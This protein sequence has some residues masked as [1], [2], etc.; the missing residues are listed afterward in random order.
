MT[1]INPFQYKTPESL[2]A[3]EIASVFVDVYSDFSKLKDITHTFI[4]GSRGTGKSMMLRYLEPRVLLQAGEIKELSELSFF[5]VHIPVKSPSL[6]LTEL[7]RLTGSAYSSF[8]EY[9]LV[10]Y[11]CQKILRLLSFLYDKLQYQD[12]IESLYRFFKEQLVLEGWQ[13]QTIENEKPSFKQ[14]ELICDREFTK[15]FQYLKRLSFCSQPVDYNGPLLGY[16]DFLLALVKNIK[17]LSFFPKVPFF[18]MLDDVDNLD[19]DAQRIINN[20]VSYRT[21]DSICLKLSTQNRYRTYR[22]ESGQLIESPHDYSDIDISRVYTSKR[23]Y[24][25]NRIESIVRKRLVMSGIAKDDNGI[26]PKDFFPENPKQR[27]GIEKEKEIIRSKWAKGKGR[28]SRVA[29]DITRYAVPEYMRKLA[30]SSRSSSTYS[31]SGFDTLVD[32]SSG[33]IRWFLEPASRMFEAVKSQGVIPSSQIYSIPYQ[34]Q[35]QEIKKWSEEFILQDMEKLKR[36]AVSDDNNNSNVEASVDKLP[37]CQISKVSKLSNLIDALGNLF[38]SRIL[39][40]HA[41]ERK[42]MSFMIPGEIGGN[43]SQILDFGVEAGYFVK[44][45]I[46]NKEGWGRN[47]M[48]ILSKR[49]APHFRLDPGGYAHHLSIK[50]EDLEFACDYPKQFVTK[51]SKLNEEKVSDNEQLDIDSI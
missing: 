9:I 14:M 51:R 13:P 16:Q 27:S 23:N 6:K 15:S 31:Y 21:T 19:I 40:Q 46:S 41:S 45:T 25:Y 5:A 50:A 12:E 33:V 43:L 17:N 26:N 2:T 47:Y 44:T 38:R 4:H 11:I 28:S 1:W 18:I 49:L 42:V 22:T 48:Y 34:I 8:T 30:G 35:D 10:L 24:Y 20:W 29:D 37:L 36:T 7:K 39:D 3:E 32:I